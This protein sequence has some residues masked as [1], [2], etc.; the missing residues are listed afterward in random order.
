[1]DTLDA[2]KKRSRWLNE[3]ANNVHSQTGEDGI[4]AKAL[5]ICEAHRGV[6]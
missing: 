3:Y 4:V 6:C 1:M 2:V 5:G